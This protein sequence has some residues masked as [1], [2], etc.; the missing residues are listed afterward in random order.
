[1]K[2]EVVIAYNTCV[3]IAV[4]RAL[5]VLSACCFCFVLAYGE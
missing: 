4:Y 2:T 1:M 5:D 3:A